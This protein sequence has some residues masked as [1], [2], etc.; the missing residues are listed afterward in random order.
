MNEPRTGD[1]G[2]A[3]TIAGGIWA[4]LALLLTVGWLRTGLPDTWTLLASWW[5][6]AFWIVILVSL[7]ILLIATWRLWC[8]PALCRFGNW[9]GRP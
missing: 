9:L 4:L 3:G 2:W 1:D 8:W 5:V 6:V 7:P